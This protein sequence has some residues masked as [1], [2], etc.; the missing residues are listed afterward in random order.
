VTMSLAAA[1]LLSVGGHGG[2]WFQDRFSSV[3]LQSTALPGTRSSAIA[4]KPS[5]ACARR[6]YGLLETKRHEAQLSMLCCQ[7]LP[8][9]E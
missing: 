8:S 1:V 3:R 7:E 2:L 6:C 9:G 5:D 4:D